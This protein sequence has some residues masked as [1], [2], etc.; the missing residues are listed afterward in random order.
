MMM[1]L[2]PHSDLS[3]YNLSPGHDNYSSDESGAMKMTSSVV[4]VEP[5][6]EQTKEIVP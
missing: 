3:D 4:F 6:V 1:H 5:L 2:D